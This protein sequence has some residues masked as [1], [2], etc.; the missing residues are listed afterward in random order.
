MS[1][2]ELILEG[3]VTIEG[4]TRHYQQSFLF[5]GIKREEVTSVLS[6]DGVLTINVPVKV[7]K[8]SYLLESDL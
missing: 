3:Q 7:N 8:L 5:P 2:D 4:T 1:S 6:S